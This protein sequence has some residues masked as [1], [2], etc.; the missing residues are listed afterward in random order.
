MNTS[1]RIA[2]PKN[3]GKRAALQTLRNVQK[4]P[5]FA[6][7]LD[8]GD[9]STAFVTDSSSIARRAHPKLLS[10][11]NRPRES[12]AFTLVEVMIALGI[13]FVAVFAILGVMSN[14]LSNA[15]VLQQKTVDAG[16]VAAELSLTNSIT[17]GLESGDFGD[18]YPGFTWTR[19]AYPAG[20]NGLFQVDII[21]QKPNGKVDST[22]SVFFFQSSQTQARPGGGTAAG[23]PAG[24]R[25]SNP[26]SR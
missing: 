9:F 18:M 8:C 14:A 21:V 6:K 1:L 23:T 7:R 2:T 11:V 3:D 17:E 22:M 24:R 26:L 13:F 4:R 5:A 12:H 10:H 19:D 20:T 25:T 15:R 16:M